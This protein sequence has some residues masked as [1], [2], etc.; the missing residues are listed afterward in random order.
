MNY[1]PFDR[2]QVINTGFYFDKKRKLICFLYVENSSDDIFSMGPK[3]YSRLYNPDDTS[4]FFM[5]PPPPH[6][7]ALS[8][9]VELTISNMGTLGEALYDFRWICSN[10]KVRE[11]F[12]SFLLNQENYE[13]LGIFTDYLKTFEKEN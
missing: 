6:K 1:N 2:K 8:D 5:I 9:L 4:G 12:H 13:L 3:I 10:E 11:E 7:T